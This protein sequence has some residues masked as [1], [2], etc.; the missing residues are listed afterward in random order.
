MRIWD[1]SS[2]LYDIRCVMKWLHFKLQLYTYYKKSN[3]LKKIVLE[4]IIDLTECNFLLK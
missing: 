4:H 1:L 2:V 3:C